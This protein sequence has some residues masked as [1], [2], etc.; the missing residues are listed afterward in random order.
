M[1]KKFF[2]LHKESSGG[3]CRL[4][5]FDSE[6]KFRSGAA[7]KRSVNVKTCFNINKRTDTKQKFAIA[8]FTKDDCFT[9]VCDN[10]KEQDEWL[11]ALLELQQGDLLEGS[12]EKPKPT[13]EHIW[14]VNIKNRGLGSSKN[15]TGPYRLCLT[16][17]SVNLLKM[18]APPE[19]EMLAFQLLSIRRCGHSDCFFFME[20]G[21]SST[22]GA[23]ELWMQ[24]EDTIIAQNMHEAILGAM[25]ALHHEENEI[26]TRS[27]SV[28]ERTNKPIGVH[29]RRST[30]SAAPCSAEVL[31]V[32]R[33]RTRSEGDRVIQGSPSA[34]RYNKA[35]SS[36]QGHLRP[37]SMY[38]RSTNSPQSHSPPVVSPLNPAVE[39]SD[40][41]TS[42]D[43]VGTTSPAEHYLVVK[44]YGLPISDSPIHT[45]LPTTDETPEDYLAM[46]PTST[47][48]KVSS[49]HEETGY[50]EMNPA[51]SK[52]KVPIDKPCKSPSQTPKD[53]Y[54]DMS[55]TAVIGSP[56]TIGNKEK[57]GAERFSYMPMAVSQ[58]P[59]EVSQTDGG[60]MEMAPGEKKLGNSN[61]KMQNVD[62]GY[63][64]MIPG[65]P[66]TQSEADASGYLDMS[67]VGSVLS[68]VKE[69]AEAT[70][71]LNMKPCVH[72]TKGR[73]ITSSAAGYLDMKPGVAAAHSLREEFHLE[74]VHSYLAP[75][76]CEQ[77]I[78]TYSLG[79][80]AAALR[81]HIM[82]SEGD[83]RSRAYSIGSR[84][85]PAT[86]ANIN[87]FLD[88]SM[89]DDRK[90]ASAPHINDADSPTRGTGAQAVKNKIQSYKSE[91]LVEWELDPET[92]SHTSEESLTHGQRGRS[93]I[94]GSPDIGKVRK[95][96]FSIPSRR[97]SVDGNNSTGEVRGNHSRQSSRG[98][99]T[100]IRSRTNSHSSDHYRSR[101]NSHSSD[102]SVERRRGSKGESEKGKA[103]KAAN[104]LKVDVHKTQSTT[105]HDY[106]NTSSIVAEVQKVEEPHSAGEYVN[107]EFSEKGKQQAAENSKETKKISTECHDYINIAPVHVKQD[108]FPSQG[109]AE[110]TTI[111]QQEEHKLQAEAPK[112]LLEK[113]ENKYTHAV[114]ADVDSYAV[115]SFDKSLPA[116]VSSV[117]SQKPS[118]ETLSSSHTAA[119]KEPTLSTLSSGWQTSSDALPPKI[120]LTTTMSKLSA[121][122]LV[123]PAA[124][125]AMTKPFSA[126]SSAKTTE[127]NINTSATAKP[128]IY[129]ASLS[130]NTSEKKPLCSSES[131][132]AKLLTHIPDPFD[133]GT[134]PDM[135]SDTDLQ[136]ISV[137]ASRESSQVTGTSV[138]KPLTIDTFMKPIPEQVSP[139]GPGSPDKTVCN[140]SFSKQLAGPLTS[141]FSPQPL[142]VDSVNNIPGPVSPTFCHLSPGRKSSAPTVS[143]SIQATT[144]DRMQRSVSHSPTRTSSH[145]SQSPPSS[146]GVKPELGRVVSA[147]VNWASPKSPRAT[148][149]NRKSLIECSPY[150]NLSIGK[151]SPRSSVSS[152]KEL[153]YA[154]LD[155]GPCDDSPHRNTS[156]GDLHVRSRN[157]SA[158]DSGSGAELLQYA[159]IDFTKSEGLRQVANTSRESRDT[160]FHL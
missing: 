32:Q 133:L 120:P 143:H 26:R 2:V 17:D 72:V 15:I 105:K 47:K 106:V 149:M 89:T 9:V 51:D 41:S 136:E 112:K 118:N 27:T 19:A 49:D 81:K 29:H 111:K 144:A 92:A 84:P 58:K 122:P 59:E 43:D 146:A 102:Y 156:S 101:T 91:D 10:E 76:D 154:S 48:D 3:P 142:I 36:S 67:P 25:R 150:E 123:S 65:K 53:E 22:T 137:T 63:L 147:P 57:L 119:Q 159:E 94:V 11:T 125:A 134:A 88:I 97:N 71:Y 153:N 62:A 96:S 113:S 66:D 50:M 126:S 117:T 52:R 5:Y 78:R 6:K 31:P 114:S 61:S 24:T 4:E 138:L 155:L 1:K 93:P 124:T 86:A 139:Q 132:S 16:L 141:R 13:F 99:S 64:H 130:A 28:G 39:S 135:S 44:P 116:K 20:L 79:D 152:E 80:R 77:R 55:P 121:M 157:S 129:N 73:N 7:A 54:L 151:V 127:A 45:P 83:N 145:S 110:T 56:A 42:I 128:V 82:T 103:M 60:Y 158:S 33:S 18:N 100:G 35:S 23:G 87:K 115:M 108:H 95:D 34:M 131:K 69:N 21:R 104:R 37:H 8:L 109:I 74:K 98:D 107:I 46:T 38:H 160:R 30:A 40:S 85:P 148:M 14:Q 70:S 68:P 90:S 12:D 140:D 75:S